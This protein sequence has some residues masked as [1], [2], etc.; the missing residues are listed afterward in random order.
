MGGEEFVLLLPQTNKQ[1]ALDL[2]SRLLIRVAE[3]QVYLTGDQ[4]VNITLSIG[5]AVLTQQNDI[6]ALL[7]QADLGL[8][9]AK[10][11]GRNRVVFSQ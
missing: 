9:Q 8:Y 4:A 6:D 3:N 10:S 2:A 1:R 5:V 11:N 7:Q